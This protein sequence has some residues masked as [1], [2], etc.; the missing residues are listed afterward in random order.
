LT[1]GDYRRWPEDD[2]WELIDGEPYAMA[3][4]PSR[5][6]QAIVGELLRQVANHL[7]NRPCEVYSAPFDVRLPV[8]EEADEDI[9]TVV[10]P[11]LAVICDLAKLDEH[12]CRGAPDWVI[13]VTSPSTAVRDQIQKLALYERSGVREYWIVHPADHLVTARMLGQDG[14]YGLPDIREGKGLME[15][16]VLAGL[17]I[18]LD[19][20]FAEAEG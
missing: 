5:R 12:G 14:R 19:R 13:E 7:L 17:A 18:D 11:D 8:A 2:R 10:Q 3:P 6:H 4:S 15:V 16:R 1:Y 20:V 9:L